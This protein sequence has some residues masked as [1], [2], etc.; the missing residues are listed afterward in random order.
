MLNY[1]F[2]AA[3]PAWDKVPTWAKVAIPLLFSIFILL[4]WG[5][6][7]TGGDAGIKAILYPVAMIE[8]LWALTIGFMAAMAW[9]PRVVTHIAA[10]AV[11]MFIVVQTA[12]SHSHT[13]LWFVFAI[14]GTWAV[15]CGVGGLY[16]LAGIAPAFRGWSLGG[17][18]I[19]NVVFVRR[20]KD[21]D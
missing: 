15:F 4:V 3:F 11:G 5:P 16:F 20:P 17:I 2:R 13:T 14:I 6:N 9:A 12:A 1:I 18:V 8:A 7:A 10:T 19:G 21:E